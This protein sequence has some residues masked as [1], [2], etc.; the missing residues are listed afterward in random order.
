MVPGV[1]L[2][3]ISALLSEPHTAMN[4]AVLSSSL[5]PPMGPPSSPTSSPTPPSN[6]NMEGGVLFADP[7]ISM[8]CLC[9][10]AA[11]VML[12]ENRPS[13][14]ADAEVSKADG[15]TVM[16]PVPGVLL[17]EENMPSTAADVSPYRGGMALSTVPA[18]FTLEQTVPCVEAAA[19]ASRHG[20]E[21]IP[22]EVTCLFTSEDNVPAEDCA[23]SVFLCVENT[24]SAETGAQLSTT[25]CKTVSPFISESVPEEQ[26]LSGKPDVI[27]ATAAAAADGAEGLTVSEC[28]GGGGVCGGMCSGVTVQSSEVMSFPLALSLDFCL[29]ANTQGLL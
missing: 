14:E 21:M 11:V 12:E 18:V 29:S 19:L 27:S 1:S 15:L 16:V 26:T 10:T 13:V 6:S 28:G 24:F 22:C 8:V 5:S 3:L 17:T 7:G 25:G 9:I 23:A 4:P 20:S 2:F